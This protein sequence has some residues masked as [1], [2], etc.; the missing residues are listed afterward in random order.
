MV[1]KKPGLWLHR[2]K[3]STV[4]RN[5][6]PTKVVTPKRWKPGSCTKGN[7]HKTFKS[8]SIGK[9]VMG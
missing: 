5:S 6:T 3:R 1:K 2:P 8:H 7:R 4:K 9:D